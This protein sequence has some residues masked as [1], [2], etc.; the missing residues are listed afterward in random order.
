MLFERR[1]RKSP[2]VGDKQKE[3]NHNNQYLPDQC[4]QYHKQEMEME[5]QIHVFVEQIHKFL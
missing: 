5:I 3:Y 1:V 4:C 2:V